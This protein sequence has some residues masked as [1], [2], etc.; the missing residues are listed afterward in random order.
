MALCNMGAIFWPEPTLISERWLLVDAAAEKAAMRF[1]CPKGGQLDGLRFYVSVTTGGILRVSFQDLDAATGLPDGVEDEFVDVSISTSGYYWAAPMRKAGSPRTVTV[2]EWLGAV[3]SF[4]S[5]VAENMS[6]KLMQGQPANIGSVA[7]Q[8]LWYSGA[9]WS[10]K[11]YSRLALRY[12]DGS[13]GYMLGNVQ[14]GSE[15]YG[16]LYPPAERGAKITLPFA[17][18]VSGLYAAGQ[19]NRPITSLHLYASDGLTELASASFPKKAAL[20]DQ[21]S[22]DPALFSVPVQL[23]PGTYY[24]GAR[25]TDATNGMQIF[26]LEFD[27]P[28]EM[29]QLAGGGYFYGAYRANQTASWTVY[30]NQYPRMGLIISALPDAGCLPPE[31]KLVGWRKLVVD[32]SERLREVAVPT[33]R[34]E[35]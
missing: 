6:L 26:W 17:C 9:A 25:T 28:N 2:G 10:V 22:L 11:E 20:A 35:V 33:R 18:K 8:A 13:F 19:S 21:Y 29:V 27:D 31:L 5:Y 4:P 7:T 32:V 24:L 15:Q 34:R 30:N 16:I 12:T 3:F 1:F 23:Q 14:A